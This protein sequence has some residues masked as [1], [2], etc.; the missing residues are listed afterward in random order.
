[1]LKSLGQ[2]TTQ[3]ELD[4]L[5]QEVDA[6]GNGE[7]DFAEFLVMTLQMA[8]SDPE[9][10]LMGLFE[11][12]DADGSGAISTDELGEAMQ[13]RGPPPRSRHGGSPRRLPPTAEGAAVVR[14][15]DRG[16]ADAGGGGR[17]G[18][19]GGQRRQRIARVRAPCRRPRHLCS[20]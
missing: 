7:I 2:A 16:D 19:A 10:E 3:A 1:M 15:A 12:L 20:R 9:S 8:D 6:D 5:V 4:Q 11:A 13:A 18:T 17:A 14:A